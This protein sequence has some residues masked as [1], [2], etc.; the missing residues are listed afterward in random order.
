MGPTNQHPHKKS[1]AREYALQFLY[2]TMAQAT[3]LKS[4]AHTLGEVQ[5]LDFAMGEFDKTYFEKDPEHVAHQMS[6]DTRNFA[7]KLL[8]QS[9]QFQS[10][11]Q[12]DIHALCAQKNLEKMENVNYTLLLLGGVELKYDK[13]TP[14]A[15]IINEY[16]NLAKKFGPPESS[17]FINTILDQLAKTLR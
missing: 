1:H 14:A 15:V 7:K 9:F 3:A 8:L 16:V 2:Q 12:K 6:A 4:P 11:I 13:E 17:G 10:E 5:N